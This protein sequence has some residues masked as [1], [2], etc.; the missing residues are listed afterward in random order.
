MIKCL[1]RPD[2]NHQVNV[3]ELSHGLRQ[4]AVEAHWEKSALASTVVG[5]KPHSWLH[6]VMQREVERSQLS[7]LG[8]GDVRDREWHD[9]CVGVGVITHLVGKMK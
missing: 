7:G 4:F 2:L 3:I 6:N 5:S 1:G 9:S 8:G